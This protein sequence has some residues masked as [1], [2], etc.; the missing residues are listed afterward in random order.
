L[1]IEYLEPW[2]GYWVEPLFGYWM[3]A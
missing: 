3:E 1:D 2:F